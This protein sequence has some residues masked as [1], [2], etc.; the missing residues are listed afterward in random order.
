MGGGGGEG[1]GSNK[2]CVSECCDLTGNVSA[3]LW[4]FCLY[5]VLGNA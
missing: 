5:L 1:R 2:S 3:V 4:L